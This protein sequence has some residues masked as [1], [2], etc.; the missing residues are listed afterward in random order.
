VTVVCRPCVKGW[1][2]V[3][4]SSRSLMAVFGS[5]YAICVHMETV[6]DAGGDCIHVHCTLNSAGKFFVLFS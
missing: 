5:V 3:Q 6:G 2:V 4:R 1:C